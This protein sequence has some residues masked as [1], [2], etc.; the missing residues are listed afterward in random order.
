METPVNHTRGFR[1]LEELFV[2]MK[3]GKVQV[4][5]WA[6][7]PTFGG[8]CPYG[9]EYRPLV[10]SWDRTHVIVGGEDPADLELVPHRALLE[11]EA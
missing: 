4:D 3:S 2:A 6:E 9:Q 8:R 10:R 5:D 11:M 7:L 1:S